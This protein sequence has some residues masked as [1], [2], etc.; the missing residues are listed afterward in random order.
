MFTA[1]LSGDVT[2]YAGDK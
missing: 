1:M 2:C